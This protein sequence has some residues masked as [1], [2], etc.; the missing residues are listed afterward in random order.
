[1]D[2]KVEIDIQMGISGA[3]EMGKAILCP[4]RHSFNELFTDATVIKD[5]SSYRPR[6]I[7]EWHFAEGGFCYLS[8]YC[9]I[10]YKGAL[11]VEPCMEVVS[12][13][14]ENMLLSKSYIF[15]FEITVRAGGS[16]VVTVKYDRILGC[17][18]LAIIDAS[19]I[20]NT[21]IEEDEDEEDDED[22]IPPQL[23]LF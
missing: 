15:S 1:M 2:P 20:P 16:A 17:R 10:K 22:S 14:G 8:S 13:V 3:K 18:W 6:K 21:S 5:H 11:D 23:D 9:S 4:D 12:A 7:H 19:T